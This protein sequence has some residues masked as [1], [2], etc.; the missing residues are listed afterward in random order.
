MQILL[1]ERRS[2]RCINRADISGPVFGSGTARAAR[3]VFHQPEGVGL[4]LSRE[5]VANAVRLMDLLAHKVFW[6]NCGEAPSAIAKVAR[7]Q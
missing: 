6:M 1:S 3:C 5:P 7:G 4:R 2:S